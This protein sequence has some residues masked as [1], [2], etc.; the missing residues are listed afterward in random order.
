[1]A[2]R[3][4]QVYGVG[5]V[6]FRKNRRSKS[7]KLSITHD[8]KVNVSLPS[9]VPYRFAERF[10][11]QKRQWIIQNKIDPVVMQHG[12]K[13][14]KL[15]TLIY[16]TSHTA[17]R[18]TSR[19]N[20]NEV[21]IFRPA[22]NLADTNQIHA[23]TQRAIDRA[24]QIQ[25]QALLANRLTDLAESNGFV[26]QA[27]SIKKL[28]SRWGS[29]SHDKHIVLNRYLVQLPWELIDY[30][31][32]HE[33]VHTEIMQHGRPFWTELA[34]YVDDLPSKRKRMRQQRPHIYTNIDQSVA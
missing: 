15:H 9:W 24:L 7:I 14:G 2:T 26:Y 4:V 5:N 17:A 13:I 10:V 22:S 3:Q 11:A 18:A 21:I 31:I 33:L 16:K 29:C 32:L 12:L 20:N 27:A 6:Q 8:G 30:V 23:V 19:I 34:K 1:M 25:A 28:K